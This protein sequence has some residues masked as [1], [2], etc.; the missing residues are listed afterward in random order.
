MTASRSST[1][2]RASFF[3]SFDES[4]HSKFSPWDVFLGSM[5]PRSQPIQPSL[6]PHMPLYSRRCPKAGGTS[7]IIYV[8]DALGPA[9]VLTGS[10]QDPHALDVHCIR[11]IQT[12]GE[13]LGQSSTRSAPSDCGGSRPDARERMFDRS[14]A[15]GPPNDRSGDDRDSSIALRVRQGAQPS[16]AGFSGE[17]GVPPPPRRE[18]G[19][20]RAGAALGDAQARLVDG[21]AIAATA[22]EVLRRLIRGAT[23]P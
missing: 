21:A 9:V 3:L 17:R 4:V 8:R 10:V 1:F 16:R 18:S 19:V 13:N 11:T 23:A 14:Q 2:S 22:R 5:E 12:E 7:R 15:R 20:R 6:P